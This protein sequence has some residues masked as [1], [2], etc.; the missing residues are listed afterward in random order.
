MSAY[1]NLS[2]AGEQL[3]VSY[4]TVKRWIDR[5][6]LPAFVEGVTYRIHRDDL[7]AFVRERTTRKT[8]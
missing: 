7:D 1:L 3:D 4:Q 8:A 6:Q 2:Q 5:G